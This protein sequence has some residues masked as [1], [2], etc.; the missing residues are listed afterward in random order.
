MS[1]GSLIVEDPEDGIRVL[2]MNRAHRLNALDGELVGLL[3]EALEE[4]ALRTPDI[5]VII[6][7]G[8]G[9]SFCSGAD[10]K[11]LS[12]GILDDRA[13][14]VAF[15]DSLGK[16]CFAL[17]GAPQAVIAS[18]QGYALAGGLEVAASCDIVVVAD[19]AQLGDQHINRGILPGAGGSQRLPRK[20]GLARGLYYLLT[21]RRMSGTEA[22]QYG[23]AAE[24]VQRGSL[25]EATMTLARELASK[26]GHA[27]NYMKQ[28]V[29]RGIEL[30]L[31][32]AVNLELFLQS[33][34]RAKSTAMDH[35]AADFARGA[36]AT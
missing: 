27:L 22:V 23:F 14:H 4:A 1:D 11:W 35:A 21:G 36:P 8:S 9:D 26:D 12:Q 33:R 29:R 13:A 10:L 34:Y 16:L 2:T 19:D 6:L 30:P 25:D 32:D 5:R 7:R 20:L 24:C 28:M 31:A 17:S 3:V 18:V 15:Q